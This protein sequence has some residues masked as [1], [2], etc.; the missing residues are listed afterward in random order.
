MNFLKSLLEAN[1]FSNKPYETPF[2][3]RRHFYLMQKARSIELNRFIHHMNLKVVIE[4]NRV[5]DPWINRFSSYEVQADAIR[6]YNI[7]SNWFE[8]FPETR[9]DVPKAEILYKRMI[10]AKNKFEDEDGT[11]ATMKEEIKAGRRT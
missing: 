8:R 10:E 4:H 11:Y 9:M 6:P 5:S 3:K 7:L 2:A 1:E